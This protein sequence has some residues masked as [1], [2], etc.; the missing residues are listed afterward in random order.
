ME[1]QAA[2]RLQAS[3]P[4]Y[5]G[6]TADLPIGK[7]ITAKPSNQRMGVVEQVFEWARAQLGIGVSRMKCIFLSR[8]PKDSAPYGDNVYR[9]EPVGK[10]AAGHSSWLNVLMDVLERDGCYKAGKIKRKPKNVTLPQIEKVILWYYTGKPIDAAQAKELN[11][12]V[13]RYNNTSYIY[14]VLAPKARVVAKEQ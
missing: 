12:S 11:L 5:H 9:M 8:N 7:V 4:L 3:Q 13:H 6:T 10:S 14:E 2:V 1:I